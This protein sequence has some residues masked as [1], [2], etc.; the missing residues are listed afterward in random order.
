MAERLLS[1]FAQPFELKHN[2]VASSASIGIAI[3]AEER[4]DPASLGKEADLA[5]H[6]AKL[7][8]N[9]ELAKFS[10]TLEKV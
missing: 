10:D 5:L 9:A 2:S 6:R 3:A 8:G 4:R 1:A 7:D